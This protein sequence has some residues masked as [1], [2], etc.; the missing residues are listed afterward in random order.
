V[1]VTDDIREYARTHYGA[2]MPDYLAAVTQVETGGRLSA[3]PDSPIDRRA[4]IID[5]LVP[6]SIVHVDY[7]TRAIVSRTPMAMN[8]AQALR[9]AWA[10]AA[11]AD[12]LRM[13]WLP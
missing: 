1:D 8:P 2:A 10:V 4:L 7:D 13:G 5:P 3:E 12:A 9:H 11:L 6:H